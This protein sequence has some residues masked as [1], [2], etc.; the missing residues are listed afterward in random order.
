[1]IDNVSMKNAMRWLFIFSLCL[2]ASARSA[3]ARI[4][5]IDIARTESP[6][7]GGA[8]F[9]DSGQYEKL[10]GRAF[11]E[12]DPADPRNRI[13]VDR[14]L[15][16]RNQRGMVLVP[17]TDADGNDLAGIRFPDIAV[18]LATYASEVG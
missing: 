3:D 7:F 8:T 4:I 16:A 13:I 18:P 14:D 15:A 17:Q 12:I 11:G 2:L 6:T 9:G 5:R 1:M 10:I